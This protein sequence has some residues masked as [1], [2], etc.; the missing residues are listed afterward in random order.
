M[1]SILAYS[2]PRRKPPYFLVKKHLTDRGLA[3]KIT[4]KLFYL[5]IF[6]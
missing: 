4:L 3:D 6:N 1:L 5:K 2:A